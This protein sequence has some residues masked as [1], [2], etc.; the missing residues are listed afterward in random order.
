MFQKFFVTLDHESRNKRHFDK[1]VVVSGTVLEA[2][3]K[4]I[5]SSFCGLFTTLH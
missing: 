1:L 2:M 5:Q 4:W 3:Y